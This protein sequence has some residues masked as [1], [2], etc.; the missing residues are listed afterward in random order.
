MEDI[1]I[2]LNAEGI[3]FLKGIFRNSKCKPKYR[4]WDFEDKMLALS[5]LKRSPKFYSFLWVLLP[6]PSRCTLQSILSTVHLAAGINA[7]L[8]GELQHC[9]QKMSDRDWYCCL[10]FD[11]MCIR[12]NVHFSQKLICIEGFE[13]CGTERTWNITNHALVFMVHGLHWSWKQPVT[14]YF[15]CESTKA[16]L[17]LRFLNEVHGACQNARLCVVAT[18]CDM[19]ANNIKALKL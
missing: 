2:S 3:S 15:S 5:L 8:L 12:D 6:L 9:L 10:S 4:R 18:I 14:Y 1:S 13:D 7:H 16:N 19:G 17:L 11:E